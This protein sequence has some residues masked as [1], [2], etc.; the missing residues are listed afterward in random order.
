MIFPINMCHTSEKSLVW[1][2]FILFLFISSN[3]VI[4]HYTLFLR[5]FISYTFR[6]KS[7]KEVIP[8]YK[9]NIFRHPNF[10]VTSQ[11]IR[12][13][14]HISIDSKGKLKPSESEEAPN[15]QEGMVSN[16]IQVSSA[17]LQIQVTSFIIYFTN[18]I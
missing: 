13:R 14:Q 2:L 11:V 18:L 10:I 1:F 5:L 3:K 6:V 16:S 17:I 15:R 8:Y 7:H 4:Q 9:K 12:R